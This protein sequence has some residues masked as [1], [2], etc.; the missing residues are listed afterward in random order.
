MSTEDLQRGI[1]GAGEKINTGVMAALIQAQSALGESQAIINAVGQGTGS[2]EMQQVARSLEEARSQIKNTMDSLAQYPDTINPYLG[3]L[4]LAQISAIAAPEMSDAPIIPAD[5]YRLEQP[6]EEMSEAV[7]HE[8]SDF[9]TSNYEAQIADIDQKLDDGVSPEAIEGYI[10]TGGTCYVYRDSETGAIIKLPRVVIE[11]EEDDGQGDFTYYDE[12]PP[13]GT[14]NTYKEALER[15]EGV[16]GL[17]Q[18]VGTIDDQGRDGAGAIICKEAPGK[19]FSR[20]SSEERRHIPKEHYDN[21]METLEAM[22]QHDLVIDNDPD[23]LMYDPQA[24]FTVIDYQTRV[25]RR[26][27]ARKYDID[28]EL[29]RPVS[30]AQLTEWISK[31]TGALWGGMDPNKSP[32]HLDKIIRSAYD[33]FGPEVAEKIRKT[34]R[35]K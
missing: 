33:K 26:D 18:I 21:L 35:D 30:G 25:H 8:T 14:V 6:E 12:A 32:E 17:E 1:A 28:S 4:G 29:E 24:G 19:T 34:W 22:S 13:A 11:V 5:T 27:E 10:A 3:R 15:G 16:P 31:I 20:V 7:M 9:D 23:N 2:P